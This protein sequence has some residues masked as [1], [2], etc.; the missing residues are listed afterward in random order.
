LWLLTWM[1]HMSSDSMCRI[2]RYSQHDILHDPLHVLGVGSF[3]LVCSR[4]LL[5]WL[6]GAQEAAIRRI[7]ECLR[8]GGWLVD[9]DGGWGTVSPVDPAHPLYAGYEGVWRQGEWWVSRGCDPV[10]RS[11]AAGALGALRLGK[12]PPRSDCRSG[13]RELRMGAVVAADAGGDSRVGAGS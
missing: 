5:F 13:V 8:P 6:P 3:D 10:F 7:V 4:L 1:S 9:E 2:S 11:Q 12:D